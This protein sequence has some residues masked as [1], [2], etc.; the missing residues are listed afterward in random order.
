MLTLKTKENRVNRFSIRTTQKQKDLVTRVARRLNKT[1]S[2]FI[3]E[4]AVETAEALEMDNA[5]FVIS[6][7]KYEEFLAV[8][9]EPTK[10]VPA[11]QKLF[12]EPSVFDE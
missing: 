4:N 2:E 9:D 6:K 5:H 8:L 11:L 7:E 10:P 3:L 12:S 1:V